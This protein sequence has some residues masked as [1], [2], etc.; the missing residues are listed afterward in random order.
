VPLDDVPEAVEAGRVGRA[1]V[2]EG[3]GAIGERPV[4]DVAVPGDPP[5]V[6]GAPVGVFFLYVEEVLHGE[7]R[8]E[9]IAGRR[10][11]DA[12]GL[13]RGAA[14]VQDEERMLGVDGHGL[15][16]RR[17]RRHLLVPPHVAA[18]LHGH[19]LA[20]ALQDHDLLHGRHALETAVDVDLQGDDGA[21]A[22]AA[23]GRDHHLG[24][25]V[26]HAVAHRLRGEAPEDDAVGRAQAR[27]G[28]H[29]HRRL[30]HHRHVDAHAVAGLDAQPLENVRELAHLDQELLVRENPHLARLP[31]PDDGG[32]VLPPGRHVPVEAA[33]GEVQGAAHEPLRP[34]GVPLED[35][36]PLLAPDEGLRLL[37]PELLGLLDAPVVERFVLVQALDVRLFGELRGWRKDPALPEYRFDVFAHTPTSPPR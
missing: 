7:A 36:V 14:R 6:G 27:A 10:V 29:G 23:V 2:H 30:R 21:A 17:R 12:L 16:L 26:V 4:D 8:L 19:V 35:L 5:D 9:E 22:I 11:H 33:L 37:G 28:E 34:G 24:L 18:G 13:P 1:L 20:G 32:L 3:G 15:E 31:F 25:R